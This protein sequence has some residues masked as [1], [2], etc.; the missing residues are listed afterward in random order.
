MKLLICSD[1]HGDLD[2]IQKV[3]DAYKNE[4]A[5]RILILGD[6]LYHGPR[7]D[8]PSTYAPKKDD[9]WRE[10]KIKIWRRAVSRALDWIEE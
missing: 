2:S 5:D 1:I 7:N 4:N 8:L 3:L 10:G 9:A 6:L